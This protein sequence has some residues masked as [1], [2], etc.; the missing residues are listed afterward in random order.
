MRHLHYF[1]LSELAVRSK[2]P[3]RQELSNSVFEVIDI[4][5][6]G[7]EWRNKVKDNAFW[8]LTIMSS[9]G[10]YMIWRGWHIYFTAF[11]SAWRSGRFMK[12]CTRAQRTLFILA[13]GKSAFG[14]SSY[15]SCL[16]RR[17]CAIQFSHMHTYITL[18]DDQNFDCGK[19]NIHCGAQNYHEFWLNWFKVGATQRIERPLLVTLEQ[20]TLSSP[21]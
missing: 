17:Q 9:L 14:L 10:L 12:S 11:W 16:Y 19:D 15:R 13:K 21:P 6:P 3:N 20:L 8:K 2:K 1:L 5:N 7:A 4:R 18:E